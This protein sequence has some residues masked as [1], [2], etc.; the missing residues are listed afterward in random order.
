[1]KRVADLQ[2]ATEQLRL[3]ASGLG[4]LKR[5]ADLELSLKEEETRPAA[6]VSGQPVAQDRNELWRLQ[7]YRVPTVYVT[8]ID[9]TTSATPSDLRTIGFEGTP[10]FDAYEGKL[11]FQRSPH[12]R[13]QTPHS[14]SGLPA[15]VW[16]KTMASVRTDLDRFSEEER[17]FLEMWGYELAVQTFPWISGP[18]SGPPGW[19]PE[20]IGE[21]PT[22]QQLQALRKS[23]QRKSGSC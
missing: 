19:R 22:T 15:S 17:T 14:P 11:L 18:H 13:F 1:M 23:S 2:V 12:P 20:K 8:R 16:S 21:P 9:G 10:R 5:I 6:Q 4:V 3:L 7:S